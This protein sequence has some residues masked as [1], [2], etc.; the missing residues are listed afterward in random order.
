MSELTKGKSSTEWW[1]VIG[2]IALSFAQA[3]GIIP[4]GST[5]V[6]ITNQGEEALPLIV[7]SVV[8]LAS[9][10]SAALIAAGLAYAYLKRRSSLKAKTMK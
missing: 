10:H 7:G 9:Q 5:V 6:D 1:T 2:A 4:E 8:N 3:F